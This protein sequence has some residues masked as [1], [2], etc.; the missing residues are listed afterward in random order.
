VLQSLRQAFTL[1][2]VRKRILFTV[3]MFAVYVLGAHVPLPGLNRQQMENLFQHDIFNLLDAFSGGSFRR[4]AVFALGVMPYINAS[5]IFQLLTIASKTV[6][7]WQKEGEYGRKKISQWTRYLTVVLALVQAAGLVALL[8]SMGALEVNTFQWIQI[9]LGLT[10]GTSFL[11]WM[12][13]QITD[14]GIG[15]G[16]SLVIFVGIMVTMPGQIVGT[17]RLVIS[18]AATISSFVFLAII[19][20]AMVVSIIFMQQSHRKVPVQYTRRIVG[21]RVLGG[22]SSFLPLRLNQA[23]VIPIIFAIS[24][25]QL[26]SAFAT[27][28]TAESVAAFV[29]RLGLTVTGDGAQNF[30]DR[31]NDIFSPGSGFLASFLYFG[32]VF[33]FTY[34]YTAVTFKPVEV[35]DDLKKWG[36]FVPGIRP[37]RPTAE[38][39]NSVMTRVT[40]VG[41]IFLG[42]IALA[43][44]W[45]PGLTGI[46]TFSLVG[47]TSLLIVVGVALDTM[48][49]LEAHLLM[50]QYEGFVR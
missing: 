22:Q 13:E 18:G 50:R 29:R 17:L 31:L 10:A 20:L 25:I 14:K 42:V 47:G 24:L 26:P 35:A 16:I 12:G 4:F 36:G 27:G 15:N 19:W 9:V 48:Q 43:P 21:N 2:D 11:M 34:F 49:Q 39:L 37:G 41:A 23:G 7:D 6:E 44:F 40:L 38:Y 30:L 46:Q 33:F 32:L 45:I 3:A 1:P 8:R 28:V 5:I